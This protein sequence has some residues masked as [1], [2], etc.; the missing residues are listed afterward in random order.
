VLAVSLALMI[1]LARSED[2]HSGI[3]LYAQEASVCE[4]TLQM[5]IN[6]IRIVYNAIQKDPT[7]QSCI[8]NTIKSS[9][10]GSITVEMPADWDS[11]VFRAV[12]KPGRVINVRGSR[13]NAV[14]CDEISFMSRDMMS[15]HIVPIMSVNDRVGFMMTTP[16]M[17]MEPGGDMMQY[18]LADPKVTSSSR[19]N[20]KVQSGLTSS[21]ILTG[22]FSVW[23]G[24]A[25][26]PG[27]RRV[28]PPAHGHKVSTQLGLGAA[29]EMYPRVAACRRDST[30]RDQARRR[31]AR[32]SGIF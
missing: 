19:K 20:F 14:L 29:V 4:T 17:S 23:H 1:A 32:A 13:E 8:V 3:A 15:N 21:L 24:R 10:H 2:A 5:T 28:L 18:W 11:I 12:A 7:M 9:A 6:L 30:N 16:G 25:A 22:Q 26:L 27:L 31:R